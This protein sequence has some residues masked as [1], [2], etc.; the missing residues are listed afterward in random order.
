MHL[1]RRSLH[2]S[3]HQQMVK[4]FLLADIGEG[5]TE[6]E[7]IQWFVEPGQ[8][9]AEFDKICEVQSDKASVEITSRFAG[10]VS[11]LYHSVHDIAKVG[12]PLVDIE[13]TDGMDDGTTASGTAASTPAPTPTPTPTNTPSSSNATTDKTFDKDAGNVTPSELTLATPAVRRLAKEQNVDISQVAGS[14]ANGRVMKEDIMDYASGK[15]NDISTSSQGSGASIMND[16]AGPSDRSE[17][18]TTMQK[19]MFKSMTKSLAIP[20]LGYKDEIELNAT[21]EYRGAL[22]QHLQKHPGVHSFN[23]ISYLPIFIKCM[24]IALRQYPVLNATIGQQPTDANVNDIKI[25]YRS[26]HN[27]G[28]AMDTPQGLIVP[29]IKNVESKTIFEVASELTRLTDLGKKNAI[30]LSDLQGGT[31]TLSNIGAISGTYASPV[32]IA[33]EMAIVALGRMQTLPRFDDNGTVIAKQVMPVSWS[34]DHRIIDGAT[35]A[36]FGNLWKTL[37]EN[38]ALLASELR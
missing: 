3:S 6:C 34:A 22:N 33:S 20:Q 30:P 36:R 28:I 29:N 26:A 12:E 13:T 2:A 21:T 10:K 5:I 31:I 1:S 8:T 38:P 4:P 15:Q 14:G 17:P 24:S 37:I 35:I 9:V 7:V 25:T 23:K 27:I 18:M 19:A 11:K 32:V 16:L